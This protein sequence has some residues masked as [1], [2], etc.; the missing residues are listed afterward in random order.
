MKYFLVLMLALVPPVFGQALEIQPGD[1]LRIKLGE[2]V[3]F[4]DGSAV[5]DDGSG[6]IKTTLA[7][8]NSDFDTTVVEGYNDVQ[9]V[10]NDSATVVKKFDLPAG[11]YQ[12]IARSN[13]YVDSNPVGMKNNYSDGWGTATFRMLP[14][15]DTR[16]PR[17]HTLELEMAAG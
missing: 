15:V 14:K 3:Q 13:W 12:V 10:W 4:S 7:I 2:V 1:A 11:A 6:V 16:K 8:V 17:T 5:P 9:L